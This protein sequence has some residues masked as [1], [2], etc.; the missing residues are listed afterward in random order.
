MFW[1]EG[2]LQGG[3]DG[4]DIPAFFRLYGTVSN[5]LNEPTKFFILVN[6]AKPFRIISD[7]TI[8]D[9]VACASNLNGVICKFYG[10]LDTAVGFSTTPYPELFFFLPNPK[11]SMLNPPVSVRTSR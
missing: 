8:S 3:R 11:S 10:K 2:N 9:E 6:D 5:S 1:S 4:S 7:G